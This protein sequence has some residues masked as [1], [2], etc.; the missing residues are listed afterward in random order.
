MCRLI[1][2]RWYVI[3]NTRL[4]AIGWFEFNDDNLRFNVTFEVDGE[5]ETLPFSKDTMIEIELS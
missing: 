2:T 3:G 4:P 5:S 1:Y